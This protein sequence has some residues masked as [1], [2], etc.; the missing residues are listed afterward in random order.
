MWLVLLESAKDRFLEVGP[1]EQSVPSRVRYR[2][3]CLLIRDA[4][5]NVSCSVTSGMTQCLVWDPH[6]ARGAWVGETFALQPGP[7]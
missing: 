1:S 6:C 7:G 3:T 5:E 2:T 4:I